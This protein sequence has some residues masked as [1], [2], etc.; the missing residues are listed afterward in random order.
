MQKCNKVTFWTRITLAILF[1]SVVLYPGSVCFIVMPFSMLGSLR[2][3]DSQVLPTGFGTQLRQYPFVTRAVVTSAHSC[4]MQ[5]FC[6]VTSLINGARETD[7]KVTVREY[8]RAWR[9]YGIYACLAE[10][11]KDF[12]VSGLHLQMSKCRHYFVFF[13]A[14]SYCVSPQ[15]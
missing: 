7:R 5:P 4:V 2:Q 11:T 15:G 1:H 14:V 8:T 12:S 3:L 9:H 10:R 6:S 13:F